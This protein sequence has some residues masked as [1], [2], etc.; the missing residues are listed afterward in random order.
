M[1]EPIYLGCRARG[2]A[3]DK[4]GKF[5]DVQGIVRSINKN[6]VTLDVIWAASPS[7]AKGPQRINTNFVEFVSE[8]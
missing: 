1:K 8:D 4:M 7:V 3:K 6:T 5:W 2:K